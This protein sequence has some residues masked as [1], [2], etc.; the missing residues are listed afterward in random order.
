MFI[1]K[2]WIEEKREEWKLENVLFFKQTQINTA[3][4][5]TFILWESKLINSKYISVLNGFKGTLQFPLDVW[6]PAGKKI[7][8]SRQ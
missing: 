6:E 3:T 7:Q 2:I 5:Q 4:N 1:K 8:Y